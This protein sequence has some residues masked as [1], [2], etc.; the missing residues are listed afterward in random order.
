LIRAITFV[1]AVTPLIASGPEF[2]PNAGQGDARYVFFARAGGTRAF[3]EDRALVFP[4]PAGTLRLAWAGAASS[5]TSNSW[6]AVEPT[7]N[8][9]HYCNQ[10]NP[11]P[12]AEGVAGYRRLERRDLFRGIDWILHGRGER[13]EYDLAV[14]PGAD[15][16]D[17]V[18]RIEGAP[19]VLAADGTLRAG[20][21]L[22]WR[23]E[24]YQWVDG[25]KRSVAVDFE[26][27][28]PGEF[29]FRLGPHRLDLE[30]AIDPVIETIAVAGGSGDDTLLGSFS[31]NS[32]N[33]RYGTTRSADW[34][35]IPGNGGRD[36]FVQVT[37]SGRTSTYFW[38]GDGDEQIGGADAELN[39]CRLYLAGWTDS[40]NAPT[41]ATPYD[42]RVPRPYAGGATDGFLLEF[43]YGGLNFA[44]YFG[45]PG[46]DRLYDVRWVGAVGSVYSF[47]I[48]GETDDPNWP[49]ATL[50]RI[51]PGGQ[52]DAIAGLLDGAKLSLT[53]IGGSGNDRAMRLRYMD[54]SV[55]A[56]AGETDSPDFPSSDGPQT[57][58]GKDLWAGRVR[59]DHTAP[60]FLRLFGG[61][62]DERFGGLAT[63]PGQSIF[64]AGTT[65]S[66][67]LPA[68]SGAYL[69][70]ASDGFLAVLDPVAL[71]PRVANYVGGSGRDEI[72]T[73]ATS[74]GDV[75][76][77]GST[78]S[79]DAPGTPAG[80]L[81]ALFVLCD[82]LGAPTRAIRLG[83]PGDD[84]I[85]GIEPSATGK[86]LLSGATDTRDW[87]GAVDGIVP[88]AGGQDGFLAS[89]TF[90]ALRFGAVSPLYLGQ[91]LQTVVQLSAASEKGMDG[92]V[93]VRS[94]DPSRLLVSNA[95]NAAGSE[96]I[97][98]RDVDG[99]SPTSFFVQ[100]L[101]S[102]GEVDVI[103]ESRVTNSGAPTFPRQ[104]LH[105]IL[106]PSALFL[107]SHAAIT[108][109]VNGTGDINFFGAP[110]MPDGSAG[111]T[112]G[113]RAGAVNSFSVVTSDASGLAV[114]RDSVGP[115]G[116]GGFRGS[117][118][119]LR[120]GTYTVTPG[121]TLIPAAP[122]Q[123]ITV[124][125]GTPPVRVFS[126]R[127][128]IAPKYHDAFLGFDA[129]AG[130]VLHFTSAD[131]TLLLVSNG[132]QPYSATADVTFGPAGTY[133]Q[134]S[135]LALSGVG[136]VGLRVD[137][138]FHGKPITDTTSIQLAPYKV[139]LSTVQSVGTGTRFFIGPTI[140]PVLPPQS[141][142]GPLP[143]SANPDDSYFA[144]WPL[145]SSDSSVLEVTPGVN[146]RSYTVLAKTA[147]VAV[148]D[149]GPNAPAE[150]AAATARIVVVPAVIDFGVNPIV[151]PAGAAIY[152]YPVPPG[153]T[154]SIDAL[155]AVRMRVT[156]S[157]PLNIV[158]N[159]RI[160][161]DLTV[162]LSTGF[163]V[164]ISAENA[165]AGQ[166]ASL[167]VSAP[168]I[169]EREIP[170]RIVEAVLVPTA[171]EVRV[172]V[173]EYS[174]D[175]SLLVAGYDNGQ[176]YRNVPRVSSFRSLKARVVT[177]P[178]GVCVF[179]D[180]VEAAGG[181][182]YF[183]FHCPVAGV[184]TLHLEPLAN[185]S[186]AQPRFTERVVSV[187]PVPPAPLQATRVFTANGLQAELSLYGQGGQ[188]AGKLT[189]SD[190]ARVR[191]SF[192]RKAPGT[193]SVTTPAS[194]SAGSVF[195]QGLA[196]DGTA[197]ITAESADGRTQT[198]D[199]FLFPATMAVRS[200]NQSS[201]FNSDVATVLALDQPIS[202]PKVTLSAI[203]MLVDSA[204]GKLM[205]NSQLTVRGGADPVFIRAQSSDPGI[206]E[207]APPD[208]ILN[209]GDSN[210]TLNFVAK[211]SG[212]A[213]LSASQ[214]AGFVSVPDSSLRVRVFA[215]ELTFQTPPLLSADLQTAV[216]VSAVGE[217]LSNGVAVTATSLDP[218]KLLIS[219]NSKTLGDAS[220]TATYPTQFYLQALSTV[221]PG[222]K[223]R[224]RLEAP[225]YESA[226]RDVEIVP[227]GLRLQSNSPL[228]L[229]PLNNGNLALAFGPV[230]D[231]GR[232]WQSFN[233]GA[234][235]GASLTVR[236]TSSDTRI[237]DVPQPVA[238][239]SQLVN[240]TLR[241]VAP[242]RATLHIEAPPQIANTIA[243]VDAIVANYR[244][245]MS[246]DSPTRYLV[247]KLTP[248]NPR[249]QP[250]TMTLTS[251]GAI[252]LRLGTAASGAGLPSATSM[253]FTLAANEVRTL[254][255]EP[256]GPGTNG[257]L[258]AT[259]A[260]FDPNDFF[261][262]VSEPRAVIS[263]AG[264][265]TASLS[266]STSISIVLMDG[267]N[268]ELPLGS[269]FGPL[270]FQLQS[271]NP[272]V[273][274]APSGTIDFA[275][276]DSRK[277]ATLQ[278]V[279]RGDAVVTLV[280]PA[281]FAG[282]AASRQDLLVT[283]K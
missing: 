181:S 33:F 161:L 217:S 271:S 32:C 224:V 206:V 144:A 109:P 197:T 129:Q 163:T 270:R 38:G 241:A 45:G 60:P 211:A 259:A 104:R 53:A 115:N 167:L 122:G 139:S 165:Q 198:I 16:G 228:T 162:D 273:V 81:D 202:S 99:S 240:I 117:V 220:A 199:V 194:R 226:E 141:I 279:G 19:A 108:V 44:S 34:S 232:I 236:V 29:R 170:I 90:A 151:I 212:S 188:F 121:S 112:L 4:T 82:S 282:A 127:G 36:V 86:V 79:P 176:L 83:G 274:S 204:S 25:A 67:D 93:T 145:R 41:L 235:P 280:I 1:L 35:A 227:A 254:Y 221:V 26:A 49:D 209:E 39:N 251:T 51:G 50:D 154:A 77:G 160:G 136:S 22:H 30:L 245:N 234:R 152:V 189:S 219:T 140:A 132:S 52:V 107:Q 13:L 268:R 100:A 208:A 155:K 200:A 71:M 207:T 180:T 96:Q 138:T 10:P 23:P 3:I 20:G 21:L 246:V 66:T 91:D 172:G 31:G 229:S 64:L 6:T 253:T 63:S 97:L 158:S 61:S 168:G 47:A 56:V 262:Y 76:L 11:A 255:V 258:H 272:Q 222:D 230:A 78:D 260:E 37:Q 281:G 215:R 250:T 186:S 142:D 146:P 58:A 252:P 94:S 120:E 244:F 276:G 218:Q 75:Y 27:I 124:T 131:P 213:S 68:A 184:T 249:P 156:A 69:G 242:G 126:D 110:L 278:F 231:Q 113:I 195:V 2:Q 277:S 9:A 54:A 192:D 92:V 106:T 24:A 5:T 166:Q 203:P 128:Y 72:V 116:N 257:I 114:I 216:I 111:P 185:L 95:F 135:I 243:D 178:P 119:G 265:L 193:T 148:L 28:A 14:H 8:V 118:Q 201:F 87:L 225:G 73:V 48:A 210:V 147:G 12:C 143:L 133:R 196:S 157:A 266:A 174:T 205:W 256:A 171:D 102:S 183:Y 263:P 125:V 248:T 103:V 214:P 223:I 17:A 57:A 190:P 173:S 101:A 150:F 247:S 46:A 238:D 283:V 15:P 84:R 179:P 65:T 89:L 70:G 134:L 59:F 237:V 261:L 62:G 164:G 88:P 105:V 43:A 7:G 123:S 177:D 239:L 233:G 42:N 264:P 130:D 18:F 182:A 191:L 98:L 80:G 175:M 153:N 269:G 169:A 74:G 149:F 40:R 275:P 55:W 187:A 267:N 159:G 85:W 137:G